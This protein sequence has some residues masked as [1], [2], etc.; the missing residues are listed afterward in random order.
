[1]SKTYAKELTKVSASLV[2]RRLG[3]TRTSDAV[4]ESLADVVRHFIETLAI[5]IQEIGENSGRSTAGI[6][7]LLPLLNPDWKTLR[8]FAF[9]DVKGAQR[10]PRWQEPFPLAVPDFPLPAK[11]HSVSILGDQARGDH[12][13]SHLP[14][15]PPA[16]TYIQTAHLSKSKKRPADATSAE[17]AKRRMTE[18]RRIQS[19]LIRLEQVERDKDGSK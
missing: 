10:R 13:P 18:A 4:L 15:Y 1:M 8:E 3:F 14:L 16:H 19:S 9:E 2:C 6:Q 7:D 5:Q 11:E 17:D 12:V